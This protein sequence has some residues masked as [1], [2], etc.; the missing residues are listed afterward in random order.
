MGK[1]TDKHLLMVQRGGI[2]FS[3]C[4]VFFCLSLPSAKYNRRQPWGKGTLEVVY[5]I[6]LGQVMME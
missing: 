4:L 1:A 5:G 6:W 2:C 3:K